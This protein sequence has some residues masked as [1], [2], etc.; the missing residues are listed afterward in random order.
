MK[1]NRKKGFSMIELIVVVAIMGIFTALASIGFDYLKAGNVKSAAKT[2]DSTLTKL[3]LDTM[4]KEAKPYMCIYRDKNDYYIF[5]TTSDKTETPSA[6]NG[7]K[8]G[9]GNVKITINNSKTI[10][11]T[12]STFRSYSIIIALF[13]F[14]I[15]FFAILCINVPLYYSLFFLPCKVIFFIFSFSIPFHK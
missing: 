12:I 9:N 6:S 2:I 8:I 10:P 11:L 1:T 5:C 14:F 15:Q 3:K 13:L 4:S 7:Q